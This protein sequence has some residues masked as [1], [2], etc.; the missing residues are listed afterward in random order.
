M[1]KHDFLAG[2]LS[3]P[4]FKH[5]LESTKRQLDCS[6]LSLVARV[7]ATALMRRLLS[8]P[9]NFIDIEIAVFRLL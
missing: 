7:S 8:H 2:V 6:K 3:F 1:S 4:S 5:L 9:F